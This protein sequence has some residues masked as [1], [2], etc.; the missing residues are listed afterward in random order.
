[1]LDS[2]IIFLMFC[3][4]IAFIFI[5]DSVMLHLL[6][7]MEEKGGCLS[8][9]KPETKKGFKYSF[10]RTMII[11]GITFIFILLEIFLYRIYL[12]LD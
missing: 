7:F 12:S 6:F 5:L 4:L 9:L 2:L 1:M 11:F 10:K 3:A 8:D